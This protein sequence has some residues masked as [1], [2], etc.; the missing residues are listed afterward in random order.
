MPIW[1]ATD[2][3]NAVWQE[4]RPMHNFGIFLFCVINILKIL[5]LILTIRAIKSY[6]NQ[7]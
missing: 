5:L 6:N 4:L 2:P 7:I 3:T 1:T